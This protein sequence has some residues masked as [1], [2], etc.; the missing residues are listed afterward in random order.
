MKEPLTPGTI[1]YNTV[2][3]IV[4]N[5]EGIVFCNTVGTEICKATNIL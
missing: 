4:G 1:V 3:S 2:S 5:N